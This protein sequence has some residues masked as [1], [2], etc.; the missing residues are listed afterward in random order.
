MVVHKG[1]Q[2]QLVPCYQGSIA[3]TEEVLMILQTMVY[4]HAQLFDAYHL[5]Y[6]LD[7][8]VPL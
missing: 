7:E 1:Q 5:V 4:Y 6:A 8:F 2:V 3:S